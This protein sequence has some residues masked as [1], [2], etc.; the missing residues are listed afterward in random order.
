MLHKGAKRKLVGAFSHDFLCF[1]D[2]SLH[3]R[4]W[5]PFMLLTN[6]PV[7]ANPPTPS[8]LRVDPGQ[9]TPKYKLEVGFLGF[10]GF[11]NSFT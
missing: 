1:T 4:P 6:E 3:F 11:H 8:S 10:H 2:M 7:H 9:P 5:E